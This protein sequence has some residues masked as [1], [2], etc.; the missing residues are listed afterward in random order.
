MKRVKSFVFN[1]KCRVLD[2]NKKLSAMGCK[3]KFQVVYLEVQYTDN[4]N[5]PENIDLTTLQ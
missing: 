2:F 3:Q 1:N 4:F 5:R